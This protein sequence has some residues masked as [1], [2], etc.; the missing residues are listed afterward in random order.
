VSQFSCV[1]VL[2]IAIGLL[3]LV[4]GISAIVQY[5]SLQF[6]SPSLAAGVLGVGFALSLG[7]IFLIVLPPL[8][9]KIRSQE[10]E[11]E[12]D[13]YSPDE[14]GGL[15]EVSLPPTARSPRSGVDSRAVFTRKGDLGLLQDGVKPTRQPI[16][17]LHSSKG[18]SK[19]LPQL[20]LKELTRRL[21]GLE[22]RVGKLRKRVLTTKPQDPEEL[23]DSICVEEEVRAC[24]LEALE[25]QYARGEIS[26]AFYR[27]KFAQ[28][29]PAED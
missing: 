9:L 14:E 25:D 10:T 16:G 1:V 7:G 24:L 6:A 5:A 2:F 13:E 11:R 8:F 17:D 29:K 3:M 18:Q 23:L 22:I 12:D 21:K 4:F 15:S 27:R 19:P 20:S 28:L 26:E